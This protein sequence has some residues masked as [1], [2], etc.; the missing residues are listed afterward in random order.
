MRFVLA[1]LMLCA[2][3]QA[4]ATSVAPRDLEQLVGEAELVVVAKVQSVDMVDGRGRPV[5]DPQARTGPGSENRIFLAL[6]VE[7]V[8]HGDVANPSVP[9]RVPLWQMWHYSLGSIRE[10]AEGSQGVF[11]LKGNLEPVYPADFQRPLEERAQIETLLAKQV[12]APLACIAEHLRGWARPE[13][14][15]ARWPV[16]AALPPSLQN[17]RGLLLADQGNIADGYNYRLLWDETTRRGY[18]VQTGGFAGRTTIFGPLSAA[19][20]KAAS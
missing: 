7:E 10:A 1:L 14:V 12:S 19:T 5:T 3:G 8:L 2:L 4:A 13:G 18:V 9:L 20:C 16:A 17:Q 11:L 6:L 15:Q